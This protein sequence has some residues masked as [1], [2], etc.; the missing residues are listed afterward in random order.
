[1]DSLALVFSIFSKMT[2]TSLFLLGVSYAMEETKE[3]VRREQ[4]W[5]AKLAI[6]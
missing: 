1:M 5:W 3:H 4:E 2:A 6:I